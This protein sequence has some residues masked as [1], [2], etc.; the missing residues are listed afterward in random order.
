MALTNSD[1]FPSYRG[2][3]A[4][5]PH[6]KAS[7]SALLAMVPSEVIVSET[8]PDPATG[9]ELWYDLKGGGLFV[10]IDNAAD[11]RIWVQVL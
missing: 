8:A 7:I 6:R 3:D 1:V 9:S 10:S 5:T 2:S 4:T 11:D